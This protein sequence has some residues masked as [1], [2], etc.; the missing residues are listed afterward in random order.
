MSL[1]KPLDL[2]QKWV[3]HLRA[4]ANAKTTI[5]FTCQLCVSKPAYIDFD[6]G[7]QHILEAHRRDIP[8]DIT[9]QEDFRKKYLIANTNNTLR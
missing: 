2:S 6:S 5:M 7:W 1:S 8:E 3:T 4:N 9:K